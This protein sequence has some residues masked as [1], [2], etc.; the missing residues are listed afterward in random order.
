MAEINDDLY[1][2]KNGTLKNKL[3]ITDKDVLHYQ[4]YKE[5]DMNQATLLSHP[6]NVKT[7]SIKDLAK[8]HQ[9]MFGQMYYWAGV[10]RDNLPGHPDLE[11]SGHNFLPNTAMGTAT[12]FING[13]LSKTNK[14]KKPNSLD[15][16]TLLTDMNELHPFYEGNG[17]ATKTFLQIFAK[18]HG[19]EINYPRHQ[20][21]LITALDGLNPKEVSQ[22]ID[23]KDI[24]KPGAP[25][26]AK[27]VNKTKEP[28]LEA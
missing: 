15:Y 8:I 21:E 4:E 6:Q 28:E 9:Y 17:R 26:K 1:K 12:G 16:A 19:Q 7:N 20:K 22:Y 11:K 2:F 18:H 24:D 3:N 23:V 5:A 14:K 10:T 13:E 27:T 25:K